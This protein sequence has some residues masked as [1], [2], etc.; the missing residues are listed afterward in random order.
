MLSKLSVPVD[1][2][3]VAFDDSHRHAVDNLAKDRNEVLVG[4]D[5]SDTCTSFDERKR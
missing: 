2:T 4:L 1:L 3:S 5:R